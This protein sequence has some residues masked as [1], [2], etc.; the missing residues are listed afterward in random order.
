MV[1]IIENV[2]V[3]SQYKFIQKQQKTSRKKQHFQFK[4]IVISC[5]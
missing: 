5:L 4:K 1:C 2:D 3:K